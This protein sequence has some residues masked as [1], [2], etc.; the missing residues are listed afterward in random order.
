MTASVL[1]AIVALAA[2]GRYAVHGLALPAGTVLA[3]DAYGELSA[4]RPFARGA[5]RT[6]ALAANGAIAA[7]VAQRDGSLPR[8]IVVWRA[9]GSRVTI[10]MPGDDALHEAFRQYSGGPEPFPQASFARVVLAGDGTVFA[11]VANMF[12]GAYS[13]IGKGVF[14]WTGATWKFVRIPPDAEA[15]AAESPPL[16][17]G[18][19]RDF[20]SSFLTYDEVV[21]DPAF[22]RPSAVVFDGA[23]VRRFG[24]GT[25]TGLA[26]PYACGFVGERDGMIMPDNVSP[27]GQLPFALLWHGTAAKRL[28]RGMPFGVNSSG[29]VVGDDR[30]SVEGGP[31]QGTLAELQR[32]HIEP[33]SMPTVLPMRWTRT[34]RTRSGAS[35]A[36]RSRSRPTARSSARS[37][38][39]AASCRAAPR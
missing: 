11:T 22:Q 36:P 2:P 19:T 38:A 23:T 8:R 25:L 13:G 9:G 27:G 3:G 21:A 4:G 16:R 18:A 12:S 10:G 28:G 29:V 33:G 5:P 7:I 15:A 24:T 35:L 39:A 1:A 26:G 34:A 30:E 37:H 6:I 31:L 20:S 32:L 14:R 17:V